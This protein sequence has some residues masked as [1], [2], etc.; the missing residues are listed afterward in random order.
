MLLPLRTTVLSRTP[1]IRLYYALN[2]RHPTYISKFW[3][4][5]TVLF[6]FSRLLTW[7]CQRPTE[8]LVFLLFHQG[9]WQ[10]L[11]DQSVSINRLQTPS[12]AKET[13]QSWSRWA[14]QNILWLPF[15]S[16]DQNYNPRKISRISATHNSFHW[17]CC[18]T[19]VCCF[20]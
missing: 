15:F 18:S 2:C 11:N 3:T 9:I 16:T 7:Q 20:I 14:D 8:V 13:S 17:K 6:P 5:S 4:S 19:E 10:F 12:K 1:T